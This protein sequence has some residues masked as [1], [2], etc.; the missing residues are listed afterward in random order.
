MSPKPLRKTAATPR[1]NGRVEGPK[2]IFVHTPK[3]AGMSLYEALEAWATPERSLRY[4]RGGREDWERHRRLTDEDIEQLRLIAGHIGFSA[5]EDDSRFDDWNVITVVRDPVRRI[6]SLYSYAIGSK[7]H[8]WH[9]L[10]AGGDLEDYLDF[11]AK[12]G[13]NTD[14]QCQMI[15]GSKRSDRAFDV[16]E[17]RF[18]AAASIENL[19]PMLEILSK[20][21]GTELSIGRVNESPSR[22]DP[23][24]APSATLARIRQMNEQD[25]VLYE[26]IRD[27]G[28]VGRGVRLQPGR[29]RHR[30]T[31]LV[32][33]R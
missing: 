3:T 1:D 31:R 19:D 32:A 10:V 14:S 13:F 6:L 20:R 5:F 27:A 30:M 23:A 28:V 26:R 9:E 21:L 4:A 33:R 22:I 8:P 29:I 18:F 12:D 2:V 17:S 16:L 15:C 11:L 25:S 7:S 24:D